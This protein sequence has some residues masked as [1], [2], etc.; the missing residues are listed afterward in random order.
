MWL[1][2]SSAQVAE[3]IFLIRSPC[4]LQSTNHDYALLP[5]QRSRARQSHSDF[6]ISVLSKT[7]RNRH[8]SRACAYVTDRPGISVPHPFARRKEKDGGELVMYV[9]KARK[10]PGSKGIGGNRKAN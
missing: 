10:K 1:S 9:K 2:F 6:H 3:T 7:P 8:D 4:N 5:I